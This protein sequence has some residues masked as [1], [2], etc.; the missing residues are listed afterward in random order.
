MV[1]FFLV[2][3]L[4]LGSSKRYR[5]SQ[6]SGRAGEEEAQAQTSR[7]VSKFLLHGIFI[8]IFFGE[9]EIIPIL[10]LTHLLL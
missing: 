7:A 3:F 2:I 1:F 4:L 9:V 10:Y 5:S 6:S 8:F